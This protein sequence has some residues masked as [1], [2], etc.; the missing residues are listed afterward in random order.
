MYGLAG[1]NELVLEKIK[2]HE[3]LGEI[4]DILE[5]ILIF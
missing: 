1:L 5:T 4:F 2:N 3:G